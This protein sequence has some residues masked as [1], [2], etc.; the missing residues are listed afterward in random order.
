MIYDNQKSATLENWRN[1][2][3]ES[4]RCAKYPESRSM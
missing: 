2:C 4:Y 1:L 3:C